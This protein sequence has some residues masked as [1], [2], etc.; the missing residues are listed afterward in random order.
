MTEQASRRKL[1]AIL[2]ADAVGYSRLMAADE[3]AT[4]E[5]LKQYRTVIQR[6]VERHG[7]RVVNAPGDSV[8]VQFPSAVEAVQAAVEVQKSLE[9]RNVE[10]AP[11]RAM[12]FRIGVNL[13]DVIEEPDGTIYGDGVNI[14]ARM[15]ALADGGGICI[16]STV[17][18]AVEGKLSFGFDFLGEQQVKNISRPIK[19]YRVRAESRSPTVARVSGP[20]GYRR[21]VLMASAVALLAIAI[22]VAVWWQMGRGSAPSPETNTARAQS[23]K[24]TIAV[25]PFQNLSGDPAQE[26]F[27]DGIS[28]ELIT[29]LTQFGDLSVIARNSMFTYKGR[30]VDVRDVGREMHAD[31][32]LEGS[33][34]RAKDTVRV[35]AQLISAADG[36][37]L[38]AETFERRLTPGELFALQDAISERVATAIAGAYGIITTA[39]GR[40]SSRKPPEQLQSYD[41]VLRA[42]EY[43]RVLTPESRAMATKCLER[44]TKSDPLY[45][46]AWA[47]LASLYQDEYAFGNGILSVQLEQ[48][49]SALKR[50]L[51][52][53][54]SNPL[55]ANIEASNLYFE[56]D[57][58]FF[59]KVR[60]AVLANPR[61]FFTLAQQGMQ[62]SW[63]G[64]WEEGRV[65]LDRAIAMSPRPPGWVYLPLSHRAYL[66]GNYRKGLDLALKVDMPGYHW[67]HVAVAPNYA[68]LGMRKEA[69]A[70]IASLRSSYPDFENHAYEEFRK[71]LW[72]DSEIEAL[73]QGLREAGMTIPPGKKIHSRSPRN[74]A[75]LLSLMEE[76]VRGVSETSSGEYWIEE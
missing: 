75:L 2:S 55:A 29:V 60:Q 35:T 71:W 12:P 16:S 53:D 45:A 41:C 54:P 18:D 32:V 38:W 66:D 10:L 76:R 23:D 17:F 68:R 59:D 74:S 34:R 13:G 62:L 69:A 26:Y 57:P 63:A 3:A 37:H 44:A 61:D 56:R 14:A 67:Y 65:L 72:V 27:V 50:A 39:R 52:A 19:V 58:R 64:A 4:V 51:E 20:Q 22:G 6:L 9:G 11:G 33:V 46:D 42:Y 43:S 1:A 47:W 25:L 70:E 21:R 40:E 48:T 8:L 49:R 7:G 30:A 5:L 36:K 15:E 73:I 31:F 24:P 28:D